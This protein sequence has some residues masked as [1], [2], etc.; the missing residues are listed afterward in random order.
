[1]NGMTGKDWS[2]LIVLSAFWGCSFLFIG[3]AVKDLPP[4]CIVALRVGLAALVLLGITRLLHVTLPQDRPVWGNFLIMGMLNNVIPFSLIVWAQTSITSGLASILN[5]TTPLMTILVAHHLTTDE[6]VTSRKAFGILTGFIGVALVMGPQ[7][8]QG[9]NSNVLA[10]LAVLGAA[11]SYAFASL[12]GRR[13]KAIGVSP[14][15]SAT[16]QVLA[17]T[18]LLV[19]ITL[20]IDQ[21]WTLPMPGWQT[22]IAIAGLAVF[23]TALAYILF[24]RL[25]ASAGATNLMLVTLLVPVSALLLGWLILD[26]ALEA[27][28][29]AGMAV[30]A[31][32]LLTLDGRVMRLIKRPQTAVP[33][34]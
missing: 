30:I 5:A 18:V 3:I 34:K 28:H 24:F 25:L 22:W 19:P 32:G 15:I 10:S 8:F 16:G 17:S 29:F 14:V 11:L 21:P 26:E 12:F 23:S 1:M 33:L 13:F 4:L 9:E 7:A 6:K 2:L 27:T 20:M 31:A